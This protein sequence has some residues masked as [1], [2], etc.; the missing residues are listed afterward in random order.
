[1]LKTQQEKML[2]GV[3]KLSIF[4]SFFLILKGKF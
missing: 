4:T 2:L 3:A 1:M